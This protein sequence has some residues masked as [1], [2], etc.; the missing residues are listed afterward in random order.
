MFG[1]KKKF[2]P[3]DEADCVHCGLAIYQWRPGGGWWD[4]DDNYCE[5]DPSG[6]GYHEPEPESSA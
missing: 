2:D 6:D 4:E 5:D 1:R 3:Y